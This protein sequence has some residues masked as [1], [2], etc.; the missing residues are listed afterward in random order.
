MRRIAR[1]LDDQVG[2]GG[3][4]V[5]ARPPGERL[6]DLADTFG[7]VAENFDRGNGGVPRKAPRR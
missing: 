4:R 5:G 1:R 6:G 3:D 2:Q 7:E